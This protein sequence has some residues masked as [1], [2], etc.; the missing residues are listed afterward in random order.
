MEAYYFHINIMLMELMEIDTPQGKLVFNFEIGKNDV[1]RITA[2]MNGE[3]RN[4]DVAQFK[5]LYR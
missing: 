5:E 1:E 3:T 2:T 4:V